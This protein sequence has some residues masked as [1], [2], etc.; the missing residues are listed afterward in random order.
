MIKSCHI[1]AFVQKFW[2]ETGSGTCMNP[3]C[4]VL[5]LLYGHTCWCHYRSLA[6][7]FV[8]PELVLDIIAVRF[9]PTVRSLQ[10][11]VGL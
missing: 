3:V 6:E 7:I 2:N 10:H 5:F 11:H 9:Y 1:M 8:Q 4:L